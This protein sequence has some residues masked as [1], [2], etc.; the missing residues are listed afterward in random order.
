MQFVH[1][2][3]RKQLIE[4]WQND[5]YHKEVSNAEYRFVHS[6]GK[7]VW[8]KGKAVPEF[9]EKGQLS[10]YVGTISDVT[11]IMA[12]SETIQRANNLLRIIIDNIPDAIYMKDVD[13][14]KLIANKADIINCGAKLEEEIIGKNDF[15]LFP[16]EIASKFWAD[17]MTV[18]KTGVPVI[19][20][21]EHLIST[22]GEEKW[23]VTSKIPFKDKRNKIIGLVGIGYD[24]TE[25]KQM[26]AELIEAKEKAEESDKLKSAFLANMSH[27]IRTPLNSILGFS[28]FLTGDDEL[29]IEEKTEYSDI[30]NKSAESLLQII[31]D[32]IDIS[33][34]ETGQLKTFV[35]P[36][37]VNRIF[38]SLHLVFSRKLVEMNKSHIILEML[39]SEEI[40]IM[41]DENRFIQ[42]ITNLANNAMKFT[43]K[44]TIRFGVESHDKT[45]AVFFVSDTGIGI[46]PEMFDSVFERFRQV[47]DDKNRSFGGNG[48][49]LAIVKNLVE[50]MGG[51][52]S[53]ESEVGKGSI[54][55]FT[56]PKA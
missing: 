51:T 14:R 56:L 38:R 17:D 34:L 23:L 5:Y 52:I 10:G 4:N 26:I 33:S 40:T 31:N 2:D 24:I 45:K 22:Y 44:G 3:D 13:G 1:P 41:A 49:G 28:N 21:E 18:L 42:I 54:F 9:D 55:R 48:L 27:E 32:I 50:L 12:S 15:D 6:D 11:E 8:V 46:K 53:V 29:S 47:E 20:T 19:S 16:E 7:V 36:I 39:V 37:D 43:S 25:K 30:I 35:R